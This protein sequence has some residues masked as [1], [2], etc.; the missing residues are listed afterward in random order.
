MSSAEQRRRE[1]AAKSIGFVPS[2]PGASAE[3]LSREREAKAEN[4]KA[5]EEAERARWPEGWRWNGERF[6][7]RDQL[8]P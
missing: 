8:E 7:R 1:A 4:R 2:P 6:V 3:A 5:T